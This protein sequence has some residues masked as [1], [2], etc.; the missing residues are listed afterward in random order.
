MRSKTPPTRTTFSASRPMNVSLVG[1]DFST[2]PILGRR[3]THGFEKSW[4]IGSRAFSLTYGGIE[5]SNM[6]EYRLA[7]IVL[8]SGFIWESLLYGN[9]EIINVIN[10]C[11][12]VEGL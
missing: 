1:S 8:S 9:S 3:L 11:P 12:H 6:L 2:R 4:P 7:R 5:G 10:Y